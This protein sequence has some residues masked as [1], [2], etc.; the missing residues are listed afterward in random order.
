MNLRF[1]LVFMTLFGAT[2]LAE[3]QTLTA[4]SGV[5]DARLWNYQENALLLNGEWAYFKQS[6]DGAFGAGQ[7]VQFPHTWHEGQGYATYKLTVYLPA[8]VQPLALA[9]P[10]LYSS[11][12][13][14]VNGRPVAKNGTV[15]T[16]A[17]ETKPQWL[18]QVVKLPRVGDT[19]RLQLTIANFHH[20]VGGIREPI[21]LGAA[22]LLE[23]EYTLNKQFE[24]LEFYVLLLLGV[25]Y[26]IMF[27]VW[28][29]KKVLVYFSLLCFT[30]ALRS[31]FS[32]QYVAIQYYPDF[33][34]HTMIR[35]EYITLYLTMIWA[36]LF[37][38]RLFIRDVNLIIKYLLVGGNLIFIAI[39]LFGPPI[40]FTKL[41]NV[42]LVFAAL[43]LIYGIVVV[44]TALINGRPGSLVLTVSIVLGVNIFA[45]DILAY[46][47]IFP[48]N[49]IVFS[50]GYML[51][52][53]LNGLA[54]L[55]FL[56][57]LKSRLEQSDRL[58]YEDF[59]G[60]SKP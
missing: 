6:M 18:P 35:I 45:Y 50:M 7:F 22:A 58:R 23:A 41:L 52:F 28:D 46:E 32:N 34:W 48:F 42:F 5:I 37:L 43:I 16:T 10:Q 14:A 56:N 13:I 4:R 36:M 57:V 25:T 60:K 20:A 47:G 38:G 12:T 29:R 33:D 27:L 31:M 15:G 39:T 59:Y 8:D 1:F 55:Y 49:Q 40:L 24:L 30:W 9:I 26:L 2:Y 51:I 44:L 21:A 11:Y 17:I 19:L 53:A 3:C 54:L